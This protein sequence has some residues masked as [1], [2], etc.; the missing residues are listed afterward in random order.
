MGFGFIAV[1][2]RIF[3]RSGRSRPSISN[4]GPNGMPQS[5][6]LSLPQWEAASVAAIARPVRY[7]QAARSRRNRST[8]RR[9]PKDWFAAG[10]VISY[11]R[12]MFLAPWP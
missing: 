9:K 2:P 8:F 5:E 4:S 6:S 12:S 1:F 10:A 11:G 7:R 3:L